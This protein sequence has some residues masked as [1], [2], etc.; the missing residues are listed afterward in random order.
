MTYPIWESIRA[1]LELAKA[2]LPST[3]HGKDAQV[4]VEQRHQAARGKAG[5]SHTARS[6]GISASPLTKGMTREDLLP[7]TMGVRT[8]VF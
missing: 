1:L 3:V 8:P 6:L 5:V 4:S 7:L 2:E